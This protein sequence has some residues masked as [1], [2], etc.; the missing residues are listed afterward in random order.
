MSVVIVISFVFNGSLV[1]DVCK[2]ARVPAGRDDLEGYETLGTS[3]S[4][5]GESVT[6]WVAHSSVTLRWAALTPKFRTPERKSRNRFRRVVA[7]LS[8]GP[9]S[10]RIFKFVDIVVY[11]R[12]ALRIPRHPN[13]LSLWRSLRAFHCRN[14]KLADFL[15]FEIRLLLRLK[16]RVINLGIFLSGA[17]LKFSRRVPNEH[18]LCLYCSAHRVLT[19]AKT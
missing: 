16:M 4:E 13:L 7:D 17:A 15:C 18:R 14:E 1:V 19:P 11:K 2:Q 5:L 6:H 12:F 3:G 9:N 8:N 10:W